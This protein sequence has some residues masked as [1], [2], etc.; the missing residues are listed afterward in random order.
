MKIDLIVR[1]ACC[2]RPGVPGWS[3][4]IRVIS[5]IGRFLEHSRIYYFRQR[6]RGR[7]LSRQC[8]PDG[9][10]SRPAGRG[11]LPGRRSGLGR[12]NSRRDHPRLLAGHHQR[13]GARVQTAH[14]RRIEP[15]PGETPFDVHSWLI[16]R[17]KLP[18]DWALAG[19]AKQRSAT[20]AAAGNRLDRSGSRFPQSLREYNHA[21]CC[22]TASAPRR[23]RRPSPGSPTPST[24]SCRSP[25]AAHRAN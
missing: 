10:E 3:D 24:R 2:L 7:G 25:A 17:Y 6:R 8:R 1:G 23:Y 16:D 9:A 15:A 19:V 4:N 13:L 18:S 14:T 20:G 22:P 21:D 12:G 11:G 5:V